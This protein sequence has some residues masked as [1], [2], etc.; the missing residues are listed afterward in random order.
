MS[1]IYVRVNGA[2]SA[3]ELRDRVNDFQSTMITE[4]DSS[5]VYSADPA[6]KYLVTF[7]MTI[8][9]LSEEPSISAN[10]PLTDGSERSGL[11]RPDPEHQSSTGVR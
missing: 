5:G 8:K 4:L 1:C 11:K 3:N 10:H 9:P 2:S 7:E 6:T